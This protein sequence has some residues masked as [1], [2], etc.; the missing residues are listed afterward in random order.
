MKIVE[1][2]DELEGFQVHHAGGRVVGHHLQ[3][4]PARFLSRG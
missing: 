1:T 2:R 3:Q 4:Y